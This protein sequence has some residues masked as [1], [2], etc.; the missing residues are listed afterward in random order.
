MRAIGRVKVLENVDINNKSYFEME[1]GY[2]KAPN[3]IYEV[4]HEMG[5]SR[6]ERDIYICL[7]RYANGSNR[8]PFPSYE[9]LRRYTLVKK[10]NTIAEAIRGLEEMG[11]ITVISRGTTQGQSN[12][13]KVNYIYPAEPQTAT[14]S[15][16]SSEPI[17]VLPRQKQQPQVKNSGMDVNT[18]IP[19]KRGVHESVITSKEKAEILAEYEGMEFEDASAI[20]DRI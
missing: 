10:S 17:K 11:L 15:I 19:F 8:N 3:F 6:V 5:L 20:L 14:E 13:Y 4:A 18:A 1:S 9:T 7:I 12:V 2:F 16:K